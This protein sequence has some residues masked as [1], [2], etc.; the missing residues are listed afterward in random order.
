[1]MLVWAKSQWIKR[2]NDF[3]LFL[4]KLLRNA[5]NT[6]AIIWEKLYILCPNNVMCL[7]NIVP[8]CSITLEVKKSQ[9]A[10][11]CIINYLWYIASFPNETLHSYMHRK[12]V[13]FLEKNHI[14]QNTHDNL[15]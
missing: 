13:Y 1:M 7:A 4:F 6:H 5:W 14:K 12:C 3:C 2:I 11:Y 10:D 8:A 15:V 9:P